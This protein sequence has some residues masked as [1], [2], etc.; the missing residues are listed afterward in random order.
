VD[1][2]AV[3]RLG[4]GPSHRVN[5]SNESLDLDRFLD[6]LAMNDPMEGI[7]QLDDPLAGLMA[8]GALGGPGDEALVAPP[9]APAAVAPD[10]A[11]AG[12]AA[13]HAMAAMMAGGALAAPPPAV[14]PPA[15]APGPAPAVPPA[16]LGSLASGGPGWRGGSGAWGL[17]LVTPQSPPHCAAAAGPPAAT[18]RVAPCTGGW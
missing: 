4:V 2:P 8:G 12:A 17:S 14:P 11:Q 13:A 16:A 6:R 5:P 3:R 15:A 10:A 18:L 1:P 7:Q 9:P